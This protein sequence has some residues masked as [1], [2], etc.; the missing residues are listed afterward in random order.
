[1]RKIL[2]NYYLP[3]KNLF[4]NE[5]DIEKFDNWREFRKQWDKNESLLVILPVMLFDLTGLD[6]RYSFREFGRSQDNSVRFLLIGTTKQIHFVLSQNESFLGNIIDE[7]TLPH[8]FDTLE[9]AILK[10]IVKLEKQI[11]GKGN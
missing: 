9:Y 7:I 10:R 8:D 6:I 5:N 3:F 1:M 4:N 2:Y 11:K